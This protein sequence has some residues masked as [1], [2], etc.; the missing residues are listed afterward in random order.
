[1]ISISILTYLLLVI[2]IVFVSRF[3]RSWKFRIGLI[4]VSAGCLL[5]LVVV[6]CF[7]PEV[8]LLAVGVG[9]FIIGGGGFIVLWIDAEIFVFRV[10]FVVAS[11]KIMRILIAISG[12]GLIG[13]GSRVFVVVG[14]PE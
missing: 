14:T 4:L 7:I 5:C 12:R 2:S 11:M 1:M 13:L 10:I 3:Y 9:L 6:G 8:G